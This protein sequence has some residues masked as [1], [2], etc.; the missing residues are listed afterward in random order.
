MGIF[1]GGK[2]E[3]QIKYLDEERSKTWERL[4]K[5]EASTK[6]LQKEVAR[7]VT[8]SER[9]AQNSSRKAAE[10]RNK[11]EQRYDE[12]TDIVSKL[13]NAYSNA[14][15]TKNEL[16]LIKSEAEDLKNKIDL[17]HKS[18]NE[19]E[20]K[21]NAKVININSKISDFEKF[22]SNYP[23]FGEKLEEISDFIKS[24]EE[25]VEKSNISLSSLNKRKKE[26]DDL[27]REIFGYEQSDDDTGEITKIGGIKAELENAY[28]NVSSKIEDAI[29]KTNTINSLYG[30][31][32]ADFEESHKSRYE[33][34][35]K[36]IENL[37]PKALTA[38]L[39]AAFSSKKQ[40]EIEFSEKLQRNFNL[41]IYLLLLVSILPV[42]VSIQF[43]MN[44]VLL[45]EV[46][47]RLPRLVLAIIPM[48]LPVL[49]FTYSAS[50]KLNLSKRLIEEY[51]H[52]EVLSKTY[53]G[54]ANQISNIVD[55]QQSEELK[56]R[57][58]SSFLQISSENPG[59][60]ISNYNSSDHPVMEALE[61]SYKFQLAIDKLEGIPGMGKVAAILESQ[62]KKKLKDKA[63]KIEEGFEARKT[64]DKKD[65]ENEE[66]IE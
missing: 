13:Q 63:S 31:K 45:E 12:A 22:Y 50:K 7:K 43:L 2:T 11:S 57:L 20:E 21:Y 26:I 32:Y 1:D 18:L 10:Y 25:N 19:I 39:S 4:V 9:E 33:N 24:V 5:L 56:F 29:D 41:G 54:L 30:S 60:L 61:Q 66:G 23:D 44:G 17:V 53:E 37:L 8:D 42:I 47:L 64:A 52:K 46:I 35:N 65:S 58:L 40:S 38:G 15:Q 51:T 36:E 59:K 49:W 6:E 14:N 28:Q 62:T 34:I 55:K 3:Q 16:S 48:Y 27:H